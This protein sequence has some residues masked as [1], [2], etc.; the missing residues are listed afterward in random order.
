MGSNS[1]GPPVIFGFFAFSFGLLF[2]SFWPFKPSFPFILAFWTLIFFHFHFGS[3]G[4]RF[5]SFWL[6]GPSFP[7]ILAFWAFIS[8]PLWAHTPNK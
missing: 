8:Q 1:L 6:F 4:L 3:L 7:F 5:P 2:V